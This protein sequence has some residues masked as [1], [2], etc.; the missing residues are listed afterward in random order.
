MAIS[1][2]FRHSLEK[3]EFRF[4]VGEP[5]EPLQLQDSIFVENDSRDEYQ[6]A[7]KIYPDRGFRLFAELWGIS[8]SSS[9]RLVVDMNFLGRRT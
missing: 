8:A 3:V 7:I 2:R 9:A 5:F 4:G 6:F 1:F